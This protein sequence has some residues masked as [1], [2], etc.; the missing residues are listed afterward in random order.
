M[1]CRTLCWRIYETSQMG[2][3]REWSFYT[4]QQIST[5]QQEKCIKVYSL[6]NLTAWF[7]PNTWRFTEKRQKTLWVR[8]KR[9]PKSNDWAELAQNYGQILT[10]HAWKPLTFWMDLN[11]LL[12][13]VLILSFLYCP[14]EGTAAGFPALVIYAP[15]M[16]CDFVKLYFTRL[17]VE[18]QEFGFLIW[19][20]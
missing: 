9:W 5:L 19:K 15:V 8:C 11:V 12:F 1:V 4:D 7:Y 16:Y 20:F 14:K 18:D 3:I 10:Q 2:I 6:G 17:L 13:L